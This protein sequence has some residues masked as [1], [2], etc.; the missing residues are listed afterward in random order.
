MTTGPWLIFFIFP[1]TPKSKRIFSKKLLSTPFSS[2][3]FS[4]SYF[5]GV[6]NKL[7]V[8]KTNLVLLILVPTELLINGK[9]S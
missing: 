7:I 4:L 1:S 3:D 8:G 6:F 2:K 9:S 5:E